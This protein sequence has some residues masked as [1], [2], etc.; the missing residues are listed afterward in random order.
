M[1]FLKTINPDTISES[2]SEDMV[3]RKAAR[4]LVYDDEGN[5]ALLHVTKHG[6]YKLPGGGL[7]G[8]EKVLEALKRECLEEIGCTIEVDSEVGEIVEYRT[9]FNV[10]QHSF[11]YRAHVIGTKGKPAFTEKELSWGFAIV[12]VT[13]E[14]AISLI[15]TSTTEDYAGKFIIERDSLF[16]KTGVD[17][18]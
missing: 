18:V 1:K 8:D 6:Y 9:K 17:Q 15:D 4:A 13:V 10:K 3:V 7:E 12:W 16:I 2:Q 5:I 11:C 14:D